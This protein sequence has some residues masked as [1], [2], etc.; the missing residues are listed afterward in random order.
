[1]KARL[2]ANHVKR[3]IPFLLAFLAGCSDGGMLLAPADDRA[4]GRIDLRPWS[5]T[6]TARLSGDPG[7]PVLTIHAE[8]AHEE[9]LV[10]MVPFHGP[11]AYHLSA[12]QVSLGFTV[13]GDVLV[14]SYGGR[15][16]SGGE[17]RIVEFGGDG[18]VI[19]AEFHLLLEHQQGEQ[20]YGA[21]AEFTDGHLHARIDV[22][23]PGRAQ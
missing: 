22:V 18:G 10:I 11:G 21:T 3:S 23:V 15:T 4:V 17:M 8:A 14:G 5:G 2:A 1:M 16:F 6:A 9:H 20:R 19:R 13:G 7:A 12:D